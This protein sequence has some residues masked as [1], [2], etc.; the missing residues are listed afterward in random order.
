M[1]IGCFS[2]TISFYFVFVDSPSRQSKS[3]GRSASSSAEAGHKALV[4]KVFNSFTLTILS[5]FIV[6]LVSGFAARYVY[7][8]FSMFSYHSRTALLDS[9]KWSVLSL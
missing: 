8:I 2:E 7:F 3:T 9:Y 6:L 4:L 1:F 5:Y